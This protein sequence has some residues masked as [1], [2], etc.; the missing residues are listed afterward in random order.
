MLDETPFMS[1]CV[2][3]KGIRVRERFNSERHFF[4]GIGSHHGHGHSFLE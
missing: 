1:Y 2:L 3:C 4:E